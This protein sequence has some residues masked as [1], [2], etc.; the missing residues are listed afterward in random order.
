M[1]PVRRNIQDVA[2]DLIAP[3]TAG[4]YWVLVMID[5]EPSGGYGLSRTNWTV[6]EPIWDDGN[7]VAALPD[8]IIR[9]A[10]RE[11][12]VATTVAYSSSRLTYP[13]CRP[14]DRYV[15]GGRIV[16]CPRAAGMFGIEVIVN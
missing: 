15:H 7:D 16:Y 14:S 12:H 4:H 3:A 13:G 2:I 11:G 8:S 6:G 1:T 9:Q 5:A 10:N